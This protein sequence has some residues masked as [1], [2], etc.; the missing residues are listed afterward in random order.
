MSTRVLKNETTDITTFVRSI[1]PGG[2][3]RTF[4]VFS[5]NQASVTGNAVFCGYQSPVEE[6]FVKNQGSTIPFKFKAAANSANC[7]QGPFL[8]NLRPRLSLVRL[9]EGQAPSLFPVEVSGDSGNPPFYRLDGQTYHLNVKTSN[10]P[11]GTYI[12]TTFDD[13]GQVSAALDV[14]FTL[15]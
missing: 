10:L 13:S 4:S 7:Q 14:Q 2:R 11:P 8:L 15:R 9:V 12:A 6:G 5:L 1:D 3:T